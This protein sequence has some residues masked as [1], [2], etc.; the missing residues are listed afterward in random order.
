MSGGAGGNKGVRRRAGHDFVYC[1]PGAAYCAQRR[2]VASRRH[3]RIR[4]ESHQALRGRCVV[5][6]VDVFH[7]MAERDSF[8]WSKWRLDARERLKLFDFQHL[9]NRAQAVRALRVPG[10]R[11]MVQAGRM[12]EEKRGHRLDLNTCWPSWKCLSRFCAQTDA[13]WRRT[14]IG[15]E[16]IHLQWLAGIDAVLIE[17]AD[18]FT[19]QERIVDQEVPGEAY[20]LQENA[21]G[22]L[23]ED[24]GFARSTHHG[25]AT[26]Q[27]LD[28]GRG[29]GGA[30]PQC[31]DCD[32]PAQLA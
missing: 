4:V 13:G 1:E 32:F 14:A 19:G 16:E 17:I 29:D 24:L 18:A 20:G 2:F 30:W 11:Q 10:G 7:R 22:G 3:C 9:F 12:A 26:E 23:G 5:N 28:R 8:E 21:A 31:I 6:C 27:I 15:H 25:I